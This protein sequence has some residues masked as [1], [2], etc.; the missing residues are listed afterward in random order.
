[1]LAKLE[2]HKALNKKKLVQNADPPL[3]TMGATITKNQQQQNL[4]LR[5]YVQQGWGLK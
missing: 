2:G 4:R 5:M 3:Q 1:M